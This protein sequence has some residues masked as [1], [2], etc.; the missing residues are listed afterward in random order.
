MAHLVDRRQGIECLTCGR[1]ERLVGGDISRCDLK[2]K[3][4]NQIDLLSPK[5]ITE[6]KKET[7]R[8]VNVV[9]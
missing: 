5:N 1:H 4:T 7:L 3:K 9:Y 6:A 2:E 8:P